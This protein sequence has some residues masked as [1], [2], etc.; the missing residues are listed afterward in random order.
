MKTWKHTHKVGEKEEVAYEWA[1]WCII[2][3]IEDQKRI[4]SQ[5]PNSRKFQEGPAGKLSQNKA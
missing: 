3:K 2:R 4:L 1:F 5:K